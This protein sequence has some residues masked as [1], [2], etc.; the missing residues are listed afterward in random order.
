LLIVIA[1]LI[2]PLLMI[3]L[4]ASTAN[5]P[6]NLAHAN[7][8]EAKVNIQINYDTLKLVCLA[9]YSTYLAISLL[10]DLSSIGYKQ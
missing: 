2:I 9:A 4:I 5:Q 6:T 7:L 10:Q 3:V 8:N 1:L